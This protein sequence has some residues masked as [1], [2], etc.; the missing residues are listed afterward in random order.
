MAEEERSRTVR[1]EGDCAEFGC[2][3]RDDT[4]THGVRAEIEGDA[5]RQGLA[6]RAF[7]DARKRLTRVEGQVT[8]QR[9][10][11]VGGIDFHDGV[12]L[13]WLAQMRF[14]PEP[15]GFVETL[16]LFDSPPEQ[17]VIPEGPR[18]DQAPAGKTDQLECAVWSRGDLA[19]VQPAGVGTVGVVAEDEIL[20]DRGY[21]FSG[22]FVTDLASDRD[23]ALQVEVDSGRLRYG[24][25]GDLG[26]GSQ[27]WH[28][29]PG[30]GCDYVPGSSRHPH[31]AEATIRAGGRPNVVS[32]ADDIAGESMAPDRDPRQR[33]A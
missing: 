29:R 16:D 30:A 2:R 20:D 18:R 19:S 22:C 31:Q 33:F 1:L 25:G 8:R 13:L 3:Q 15:S 17:V 4:E 26:A 32:A 9:L 14:G 11:T 28:C 7:H 23:P 24:S 21:G 6:V 10:G 5:S 12:E 27:I